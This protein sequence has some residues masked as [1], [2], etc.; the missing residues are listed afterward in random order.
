MSIKILCAFRATLHCVVCRLKEPEPAQKQFFPR[1]G[2]KFRYSGRTQY[3]TRQSASNIERPAPYFD[4][5]HSNR[6]K[7]SRS[8]DGGG[9]DTVGGIA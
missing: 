7:S 4:R 8:V 1:F 5:G 9:N 3:Q 2:S 6:F